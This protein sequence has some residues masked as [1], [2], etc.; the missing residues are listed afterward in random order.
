VNGDRE[1]A[2]FMGTAAIARGV[3]A[4]AKCGCG[5]VLSFATDPIGRTVEQCGGCGY[6][7]SVR[8]VGAVKPPTPPRKRAKVKRIPRGDP[9]RYPCGHPRTDENSYKHSGGWSECRICVRD[10]MRGR[11]KARAAA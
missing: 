11:K 7:G 8:L 1:L 9:Q 6:E 10:R 5:G 3:R 4:A 2:R